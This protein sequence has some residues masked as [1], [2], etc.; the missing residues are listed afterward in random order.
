MEQS[1]ETRTCICYIYQETPSNS[2]EILCRFAFDFPQ[3][4]RNNGFVPHPPTNSGNDGGRIEKG[5]NL[6][7][8]KDE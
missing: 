2:T 4:P 5:K 1:R 6:R 8:T 3:R 7:I